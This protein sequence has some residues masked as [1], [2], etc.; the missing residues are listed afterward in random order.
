MTRQVVSSFVK[1]M[2]LAQNRR[3]KGTYQPVPELC[4]IM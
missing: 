2:I 1:T 4:V 3:Y